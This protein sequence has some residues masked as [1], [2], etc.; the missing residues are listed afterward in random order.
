MFFFFASI[1]YNIYGGL[2]AVTL[3]TNVSLMAQ[4]KVKR[5]RHQYTDVQASSY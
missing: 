3:T 4:G 5:F 2:M 1:K